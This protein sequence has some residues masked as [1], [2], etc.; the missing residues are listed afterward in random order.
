MSFNIPKEIKVQMLTERINSLNLE[1]YQHE[2]NLKSAEA[3]GNSEV[4]E[5][6]LASIAVIKSAIEVH[7]KELADLA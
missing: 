2:L 7:E 5:S 1:G 3:I 4:I 6:S